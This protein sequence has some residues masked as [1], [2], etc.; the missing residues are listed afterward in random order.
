METGKSVNL[1]LVPGG[2]MLFQ[3]MWDTGLAGAF[4]EPKQG[5]GLAF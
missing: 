1:V 4:K 3:L 5:T 2:L